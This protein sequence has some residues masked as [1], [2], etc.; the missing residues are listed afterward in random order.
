MSFFSS[1]TLTT[2]LFNPDNF[3]FSETSLVANVPLVPIDVYNPS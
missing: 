3:S 1:S 2:A